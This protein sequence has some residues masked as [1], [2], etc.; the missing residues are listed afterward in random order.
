MTRPTRS[1]VLLTLA[2]VANSAMSAAPKDLDALTFLLGTWTA[3]GGGKPGEGTGSTTFSLSLQDRIILRTNHADYPATA[4]GPASRHDDL[5][6]IHAG[7]A[8]GIRA[9]YYDN[10]GHVIHYAVTSATP[11]TA[12]FVSDPISGAPRFRLEYKLGENG[13]LKGEFAVAPPG[14]PEGF[15]PYL[16]WESRPSGGGGAARP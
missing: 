6:V 7:E 5:M 16:T 14:K 9:E 10:E 13:T 1:A 11:G 15:S 8:G 12:T 3:S 4:K 2:L